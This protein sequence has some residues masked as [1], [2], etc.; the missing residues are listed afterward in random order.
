MIRT[1]S[2][3]VL[4]R[5]TRSPRLFLFPSPTREGVSPF[6]KGGEEFGNTL[7]RGE[8][9]KNKGNIVFPAWLVCTDFSIHADQAGTARVNRMMVEREAV[10]VVFGA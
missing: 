10:R 1:E 8:G 9:N 4:L 7:T 6:E 3:A 2:C 5:N